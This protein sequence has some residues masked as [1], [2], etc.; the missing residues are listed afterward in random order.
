MKN[1]I[2]F[3]GIIALAAVIGFSFTAC[4][5]SDPGPGSGGFADFISDI[6]ISP[7]SLSKGSVAY[8]VF[9]DFEFG[10][11]GY[12]HIISVIP[13]GYQGWVSDENRFAAFWTGKTAEDFENLKYAV[14]ERI[15]SNWEWEDES[16]DPFLYVVARY[17]P[18]NRELYAQVMFSS[19]NLPYLE[20]EFPAGLLML[21]LYEDI[22]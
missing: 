3:F 14:D 19:V 16:E 9:D 13:G 18:Y 17:G 22:D 10:Q 5:D 4:G 2:K 8:D 20:T 21:V 15:L 7:S 12:S 11:S 1:Y 6:G